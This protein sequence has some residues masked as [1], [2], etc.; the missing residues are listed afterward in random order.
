MKR[1]MLIIAAL[2]MAVSGAARAENFM[3]NGLSVKDV[4]LAASGSDSPA[5]VVEKDEFRQAYLTTLVGQWRGG[6][7]LDSWNFGQ[8]ETAIY[9]LLLKEIKSSKD[10]TALKMAENDLGKSI[11]GIKTLMINEYHFQLN[12]NSYIKDAGTSV[13]IQKSYEDSV[14]KYK[15]LEGQLARTELLLGTVKKQL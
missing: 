14:S 6:V 10:E 7:E 2:L 12:C 8:D 5:P 3:L 15:E 1:T 13:S 9:S 11:S 4:P